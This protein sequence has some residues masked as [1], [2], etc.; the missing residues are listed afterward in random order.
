MAEVAFA[1][2]VV[3][4]DRLAPLGHRALEP[5]GQDQVLLPPQGQLEGLHRVEFFVGGQTEIDA[6]DPVQSLGEV[7]D[8][9]AGREGPERSIAG[10]AVSRPPG[11]GPRGALHRGPE[12]QHVRDPPHDELVFEVV[13]P[14]QV[15]LDQPELTHERRV[16]EVLLQGRVEF[17]DEEGIVLRERGDERRID[18]EVVLRRM[19]GSARSPVAG[20]GL[21]EE[22]V[23]SLRDELALTV[24]RRSHLAARQPD[25]GQGNDENAY[26]RGALVHPQLLRCPLCTG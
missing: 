9:G 13:E 26:H 16:L 11:A 14:V 15:L 4:K 23:S 3:E 17:G 22:E 10:S 2:L 5:Q 8:D 18:G 6:G 21:V 7:L 25:A 19:A 20:E 12:S 24:R 1:E